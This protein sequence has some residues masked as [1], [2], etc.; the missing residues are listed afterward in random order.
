MMDVNEIIGPLQIDAFKEV[1]AKANAEIVKRG[2]GSTFKGARRIVTNINQP[3][4]TTDVA[5]GVATPK[6][7]NVAARVMADARD[8]NPLYRQPASE[9]G[10]TDAT[11][12]PGNLLRC[13][14][15]IGVIFR[16]LLQ[17]P[18][19]RLDTI[20]SL[21]ASMLRIKKGDVEELRA[22]GFQ[23][24]D[25]GPAVGTDGA[26][27]PTSVLQTAVDRRIMPIRPGISFGKDEIPEIT[28]SHRRTAAWGAAFELDFYLLG[29]ESR[30]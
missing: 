22:M 21:D 13:Y 23:F 1:M 20:D 3:I 11:G 14:F 6:H 10:L 9:G 26:A 29:L 25:Y 12:A 7:I 15:G 30:V 16:R 27:T 24:M 28:F 18:A 4:A 19:Q 2:G 5:Q 8:Q 17:T